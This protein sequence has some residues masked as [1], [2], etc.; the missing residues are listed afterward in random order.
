MACGCLFRL[1]LFGF[2]TLVMLVGGSVILATRPVGPAYHDGAFV[3]EVD[4]VPHQIRLSTE[5]AR[6]F[7]DLL[8]GRLTLGDLRDAATGGVIV[9]EEELNSRVAEELAARGVTR[10]DTR[11]E[12]VFIR[13]TPG[14]ARAYVYT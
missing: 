10:P 13:L 1:V 4:G 2:L 6:R 5:A 11:V 3:Y 9:T 12:R 8:A 14:T 7:D